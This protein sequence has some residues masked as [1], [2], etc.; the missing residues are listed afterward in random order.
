MPGGDKRKFPIFAI[1]GITLIPNADLV[2]LRTPAIGPLEGKPA[3]DHWIDQK[4]RKTL[5][6]PAA[7]PSYGFAIQKE[8][9]DWAVRRAGAAAKLQIKS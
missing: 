2:A 3:H 1:E 4:Q 9:S 5:I 7:M 8:K 6:S